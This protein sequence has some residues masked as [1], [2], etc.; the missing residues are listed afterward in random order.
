VLV[1]VA[2]IYPRTDFAEMTLEMWRQVI[3][4]NLGGTFNAA[5][6]ASCRT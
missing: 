1:V 3:D 5:H 2:G 6:A 4:I